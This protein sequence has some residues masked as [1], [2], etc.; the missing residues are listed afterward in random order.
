ML[1]KNFI[2]MSKNSLGVK[3]KQSDIREIVRL[4]RKKDKGQPRNAII[5]FHD[6]STREKVHEQRKKLLTHKDPKRNVYINDQLTKHRQNMLYAARHLVKSKKLFG[7]WTQ[8]GNILVKQTESSKIVQVFN[9]EDL[10]SLKNQENDI[11]SATCT[12]LSRSSRTRDDFESH[13][14]GYSFECDSDY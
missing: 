2:K 7:A 14:S 13:L 8:S 12:N 3:L 1:T 9:H 11:H 5:K 10:M 4:G 6:K